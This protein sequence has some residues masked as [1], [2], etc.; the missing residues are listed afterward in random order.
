[1]QIPEGDREGNLRVFQLT[2]SVSADRL[3]TNTTIN[4]VNITTV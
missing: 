3:V 2:D 4:V 1:M